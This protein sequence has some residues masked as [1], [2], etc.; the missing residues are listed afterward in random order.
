MGFKT[1]SLLNYCNYIQKDTIDLLQNEFGWIN[2]ECKHF[3]NI[4]TRFYQG[5]VLPSKFGIDKRKAHLSNL[6]F[7]GQITKPEALKILESPPYN[8]NLQNQDRKYV[9]KKLG[10]TDEDFEL[11]LKAPNI[12]HILYGTDINHRKFIYHVL[13]FPFSTKIKNQLKHKLF[14]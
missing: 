4:Y 8:A 10:F 12:P 7:S 9:A 11:L 14:R 13:S 3:E 2:Y 5:V 6:I 1:V